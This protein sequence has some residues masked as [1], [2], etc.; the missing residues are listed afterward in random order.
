MIPNGFNLFLVFWLIVCVLYL[1]TLWCQWIRETRLR[2]PKCGR[3][4]AQSYIVPG[5]WFCKCGEMVVTTKGV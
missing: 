5:T 4:M 2:C 3:N 1:L